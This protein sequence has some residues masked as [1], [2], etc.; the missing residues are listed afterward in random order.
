MGGGVLFVSHG[1]HATVSSSNFIFS[2]ANEGSG[3]AILVSSRSPLD[4]DRS[5]IKLKQCMINHS[6]AEYFGA[7]L[8]S[9]M[10]TV[11]VVDSLI[12]VS[13]VTSLHEVFSTSGGELTCKSSCGHGSFGKCES[14]GACASCAI[15]QCEVCPMGKFLNASGATYGSQCVDC[16]LG[17][18]NGQ[19]GAL[20]MNGYSNSHS[21]LQSPTLVKSFNF[22]M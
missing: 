12:D 16:P 9:V 6:H 2:S 19:E 5:S 4:S 3:G 21:Q 1:G 8:R 13:T 22:E 11:D 18:Y 10:A 17:Y 20:Y 14:V 7:V 15:G